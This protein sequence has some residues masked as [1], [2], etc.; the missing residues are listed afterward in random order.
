MRHMSLPKEASGVFQ[1]RMAMAWQR[2]G[3]VA[4][5]KPWFLRDSPG[6]QL[7]PELDPLP[8]EVIFDWITKSAFE[9]PLNNALRDAGLR[10]IGNAILTDIRT[11][12]GRPE[13]E[14]G[15]LI[16]C[17]TACRRARGTPPLTARAVVQRAAQQRYPP[18]DGATLTG[19]KAHRSPPCELTPTS[20]VP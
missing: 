4:D 14:D 19:R 8:S 5:V 9:G 3:S 7:V 6:F 10:F 15:G 2:V 12:A 11:I 18:D 13:P 17:G 20:C 16:G 1:L